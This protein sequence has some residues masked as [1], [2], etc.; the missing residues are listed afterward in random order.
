[1][2]ESNIGVPLGSVLGPVLFN[3][4]VAG[5]PRILESMGVKCHIYANNT[6]FVVTFDKEDEMSARSKIVEIFAAIKAF[7]SKTV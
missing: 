3:C 1:M 7:M 4:V 6:Q 2:K 5:L